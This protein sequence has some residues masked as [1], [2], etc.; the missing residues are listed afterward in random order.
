M[1]TAE[2][3]EGVS[4]EFYVTPALTEERFLATPPVG[5]AV[6][7]A[8]T[9]TLDNEKYRGVLVHAY[10]LQDGRYCLWAYFFDG[11]LDRFERFG[12]NRVRGILETLASTYG[13]EVT[14]DL[15][16][17]LGQDDWFSE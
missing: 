15:G 1:E 11:A 8:K 9:Y 13:I 10:T 6:E 12:V 5:L 4:T 14:D 16:A 17:K 3:V 2:E 7:L